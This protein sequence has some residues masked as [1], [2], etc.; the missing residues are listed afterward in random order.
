M[1]ETVNEEDYVPVSPELILAAVL[2]TM[3]KVTIPV[4]SLTKTYDNHQ[5]KVD[6]EQE[7]FITLEL[8]EV[9]DV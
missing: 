6:Q 4:E 9:A 3:G 8:V 1:T 5:I 2:K 7:D